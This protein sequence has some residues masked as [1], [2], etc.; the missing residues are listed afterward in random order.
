MPAATRSAAIGPLTLTI[1]F[2]QTAR[3]PLGA[4]EC[5]RACAGRSHTPTAPRRR[6]KNHKKA[7]PSIRMQ[8]AGATYTDHSLAMLHVRPTIV[9]VG[10]AAA[11]NIACIDGVATAAATAIS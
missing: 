10:C 2:S 9:R 11:T 4:Q 1:Y 7:I 8:N 5:A 3:A 6:R